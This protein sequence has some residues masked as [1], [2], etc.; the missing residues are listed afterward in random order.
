MPRLTLLVLCLLALVTRSGESQTAERYVIYLHGRIVETEQSRRPTDERF[1]PFEYDAILDSLRRPGFVVLSEQRPPKTNSDSFAIHVAAQVD[2]LV[3]S[4]VSPDAITVMGFSKGGWIAILTSA[5][6]RNPA[7][8]FVIMAGCGSWAFD[9]QDLYVTGR[10]LSL[11]ETSDSMGVS[12]APL[13]ARRSP[14]SK[15]REIALSLGLGHGTFFQPRSAWLAPAITWAQG[16]E[17]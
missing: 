13:F 17:P 11:Y 1:G 12:C 14:R 8:S 10:L 3:Q 6:L 7:V 4:G 2:S 9:R 5:R 16:Q 15:T